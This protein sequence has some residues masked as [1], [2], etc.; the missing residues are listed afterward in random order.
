MNN[1]N[2]VLLFKD[3]RYARI[4]GNVYLYVTEDN[5]SISESNTNS[6]N[7]F[8]ME[9]NSDEEAFDLITFLSKRL[10]SIKTIKTLN[11]VTNVLFT[12]KIDTLSELSDIIMENDYVDLP[13]IVNNDNILLVKNNIASIEKDGDEYMV[14]SK[15]L[16]TIFKPKII[17][18]E[19]Y[20]KKGCIR[21]NIL[22]IKQLP[23]GLTLLQ[24]TNS[25]RSFV[26]NLE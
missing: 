4:I 13:D 23:K 14:T 9:L 1:K 11:N 24:D 8:T 3:D 12:K 6:V 19:Q 18:N 10:Y 25:A 21:H 5:S 20:Y 2:R 17:I 15:S 7:L 16:N 22:F 26:N